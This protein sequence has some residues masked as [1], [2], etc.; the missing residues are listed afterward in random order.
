MRW[1]R[2][3]LSVKQLMIVVAAVAVLLMVARDA[4][5]RRLLRG[6]LNPITGTIVSVKLDPDAFDDPFVDPMS[7]DQGDP[8]PVRVD[9]RI[10]LDTPTPPFR[11]S[12][13]VL[14][15]VY[16]REKER[17][18]PIDSYTMLVPLAISGR[19]SVEGNFVWN[20]LPKQPGPYFLHYRVW[21]RDPLGE[22]RFVMSGGNR[23]II[24]H[25]KAPNSRPLS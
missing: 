6:Y 22:W 19:E 12:Y 9:Y 25:P 14:V 5:Q 23:T 7:F 1:P 11:A 20:A 3:R 16:L 24:V 8:I 17:D 13:P 4:Q 10:K 15:M 18:L 21:Y 2:I